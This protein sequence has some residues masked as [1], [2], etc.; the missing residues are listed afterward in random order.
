VGSAFVAMGL[1]AEVGSEFVGAGMVA[2]SDSA[3]AGLVVG[4]ELAEAR[5]VVE[6]CSYW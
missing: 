6:E 4:S 1:F 5:G 3:S 2:A